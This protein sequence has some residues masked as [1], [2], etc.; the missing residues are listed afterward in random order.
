MPICSLFVSAICQV[1]THFTDELLEIGSLMSKIV[2]PDMTE[3]YYLKHHLT[4]NL[5]GTVLAH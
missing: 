1:A 5:G 2:S 4:S 3:Q